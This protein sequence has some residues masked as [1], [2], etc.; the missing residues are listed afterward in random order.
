MS[1]SARAVRL[2]LSW[3]A[4]TI[5]L[6]SA[7]LL[8][9]EITAARLIAPYVGVTLYS[10]TSIIGVILAGLS[11]GNWL[12]GVWADRGAAQWQVGLTPW[13]FPAFCAWPR[14]WCWSS[15]RRPC[16]HRSWT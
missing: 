16:R 7:V 8:V 15:W 14:C 5:F 6:S 13:C 11:L 2:T 4:L 10:W 12:G 9:I 3:Y 1:D